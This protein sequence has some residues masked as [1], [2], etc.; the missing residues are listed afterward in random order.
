MTERI[1]PES[2]VVADNLQVKTF[3]AI[4]LTTHGTEPAITV[5]Y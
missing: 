3:V 5:G 1:N 4:D 2:K